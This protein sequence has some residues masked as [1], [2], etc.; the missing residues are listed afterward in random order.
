LGSPQHGLSW[1]CSPAVLARRCRRHLARRDDLFRDVRGRRADSVGQCSHEP[2]PDRTRPRRR[3]G[4]DTPPLR[5]VAVT[6][7]AELA[8]GRHAQA[9]ATSAWIAE[10]GPC[11]GAGTGAESTRPTR[12][13]RSVLLDRSGDASPRPSEGSNKDG[14]HVIQGNVAPRHH[15]YRRA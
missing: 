1:R 13:P 7:L 10:A 8:S 2:M 6:T 9:I 14:A 15:V 4:G 5:L 12:P 11:R 3:S